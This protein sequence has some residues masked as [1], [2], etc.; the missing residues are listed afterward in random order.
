[1]NAPIFHTVLLVLRVLL[2]L[3]LMSYGAYALL[4]VWAARQWRR[5]ARPL[6][7]DW[8][9]AVTILKPLCGMDAEMYANFR[10]CLEQDYP[11]ERM[12]IIFGA[13]DAA[14][15]GLEVA[16]RL[17][18][19]FPHLDI[20]IVAGYVPRLKGTNYKV[21]NLTAM[22]TQA[23]YDLLVLCDSDV[24]VPRDYLRR[25]V[26]P[27]EDERVG[28][29]TCPYHGKEIHS[30]AAILEALGM[31]ADFIPSTMTARILEGVS[32]ALGQ[33]IALPRR[34]LEQLGGFE[35][36]AN[37]LADDYRLGNGA[38]KLGYEVILSDCMVDDVIGREKF[39]PMW[40]RRLRWARTS[41]A[42]RPVGY[43]GSII[44]YGIP[45]G[46]L[47]LM[48]T[49][50]SV[51]GWSVFVAAFVLR[52]TSVLMVTQWYTQDPNILRYLPFLPLSDFCSFA[53]FVLSYCGN[54]VKWRGQQFRLLPGCRIAAVN[55][56][57]S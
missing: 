7:P 15:A 56:K 4:T 17:Q 55:P 16:R 39:K 57:S 47:F 14:D 29:V 28:L 34:V 11:T 3:M 31:G 36:I 41:R 24:R 9:P 30:F 12:Q 33:T 38:K 23:K 43:A 18:L 42:L 22:M 13:L 54:R 44:T 50:F 10:S 32:F 52:L 6:N 27:F 51:V 46:F 53:L 25:V 20:T 21:C 19:E 45:L 5:S 40:T 26:A 35:S 49:G 2:A 37:E 1:M 48:A 8:T